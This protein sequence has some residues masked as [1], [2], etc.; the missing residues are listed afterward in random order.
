MG[1]AQ[2]LCLKEIERKEGSVR[3]RQSKI[4][5]IGFEKKIGGK[6]IA[7]LF[8][9]WNELLLLHFQGEKRF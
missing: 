3:R 8:K 5:G 9:P 7:H 1:R 6:E 2:R 4:E